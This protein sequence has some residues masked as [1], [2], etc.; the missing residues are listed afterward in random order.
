LGAANAARVLAD[1]SGHWSSRNF[2]LPI[3]AWERR[4]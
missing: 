2:A 4:T 1:T 3:R